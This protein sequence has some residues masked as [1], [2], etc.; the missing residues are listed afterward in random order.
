M[1]NE[2]GINHPCPFLGLLDDAE[3]TESF[4]SA[5]NY[6]HHSRPITSPALG[7]QD[8]VCLRR[9][10][11]ECP[12]FLSRRAVPLPSYARAA[13]AGNQRNSFIKKFVVGFVALA[14]VFLLIWGLLSR[15][16]PV[17]LAIERET[18]TPL[19][20]S[21]STATSLPLPTRT[22]SLSPT[23]SPTATDHVF[24]GFIENTVTPTR[25]YMIYQT[26]TPSSTPSQLEVPIGTD[27]KFVIHKVQTGESFESLAAKYNTSAEAIVAVNHGQGPTAWVDALLIIPLGF[28]DTTKLPG[29]V[30]YQVKPEQRGISVENMAKSLR[31]NPLDLKYY[32][33]WTD[34]GDRPLVGDLLLV[35]RPRI[36]P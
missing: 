36:Q 28:T 8:R 9:V 15:E 26:A 5:W 14:C 7:H 25:A 12:V 34:P 22:A 2:T 10:H 6:C 3:T 30:I 1:S 35:P 17:P 31:V 18:R 23:L 16:S 29:F 19:P 24:S 21:S 4:P 33:G 32:N 13:R 11:L 27:Y 20:F